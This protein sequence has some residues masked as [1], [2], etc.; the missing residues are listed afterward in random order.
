MKVKLIN[1]QEESFGGYENVFY[2]DIQT[3]DNNSCFEIY[4]D[5]NI[6]KL[7]PNQQ[8]DNFMQ[9]CV[10]KLRKKGEISISGA[11][12]LSLFSALINRSID[13]NVLSEALGGSLG[14][15][16]SRIVGK[17]LKE[18][19]IKILSFSIFDNHFSVRGIRE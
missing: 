14:F 12:S 1:K 10:S 13:E 9:V 3:L 18:N 19:N 6:L 2:Q 7:I 8:F 11:N 15:Y 4:I 16:N 17:K 5:G